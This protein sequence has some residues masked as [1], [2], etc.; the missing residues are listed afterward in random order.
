MNIT[1]HHAVLLYVAWYYGNIFGPIMEN[2]I[3]LDILIR[4]ISVAL[5]T[6][7]WLPKRLW[8]N[9]DK[10]EQINCDENITK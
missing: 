6:I 2:I 8:R 10:Y 5:G 9:P 3:F 1:V 7:V 4:V